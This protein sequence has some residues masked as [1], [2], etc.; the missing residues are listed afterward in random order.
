MNLNDLLDRCV[1]LG[2]R[3]Q[4]IEDQLGLSD[5]EGLNAD[6]VDSEATTTA[7]LVGKINAKDV[8]VDTDRRLGISFGRIRVPSQG[9][10][11]VSG[12]QS[13]NDQISGFMDALHW[14]RWGNV[15]SK[16]LSFV[17]GKGERLSAASQAIALLMSA[18]DGRVPVSFK[19]DLELVE[20]RFP[21]LNQGSSIRLE[22]LRNQA[23]AYNSIPLLAQR[24]REKVTDPCFQWVRPLTSRQ[25]S[26]RVD[27]LEICCLI[28]DFHGELGIGKAG[29]KGGVSK[30]RNQFLVIAG[31]NEVRFDE[32]NLDAAARLISELVSDRRNGVLKTIQREHLL[33][34]R[35]LRGAVPLAIGNQQLELVFNQFP[36]L[37]SEGNNAKF[38][39]LIAKLDDAP[40]VVELKVPE[41][42]GQGQYYRNAVGQVA[43][44]REFIRRATGLHQWFAER[45]LDATQCQAAVAFP[46]KGTPQQR[47]TAL[48]PIQYLAE[49]FDVDVI[50]LP[51]EWNAP[52]L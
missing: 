4:N 23:N 9:I 34:T 38:I 21:N 41:S 48:E 28:D 31:T 52:N 12:D 13:E 24:I 7:D 37:W 49:L 14:H 22:Q 25:W 3:L 42:G 51:D 36:A 1:Q 29:I 26:G 6:G 46:M 8:T 17:L 43:L 44:Y 16:P 30:A 32:N 50:V 40:V 11:A 5:E 45:N 18:L 47:K 15:G 35:I 33:E 27:G 19:V 10:F 2:S 39:D 20:P